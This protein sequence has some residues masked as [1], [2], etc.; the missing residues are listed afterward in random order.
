MSVILPRMTRFAFAL[1]ALS[2]VGCGGDDP[3]APAVRS[4][5]DRAADAR[6]PMSAACDPIDP[7]RCALPW[8]SNTFT[9][10]DPTSATRLRVAI[11][12]ALYPASDDPRE[13]NRADG[14]SRVSPV[15]TLVQGTVD[16]AMLGDG[17]GPFRVYAVR[18]G[19]LT[20]VPLRFRVIAGPSTTPE[21]LVIAYP[22]A[23]MAGAT[24][25]IAVVLDSLPTAEN[26]ALTASP[27]VRAALGLAAPSTD[28]QSRYRAY[29]APTRALLQRAGVDLARVARVWDF[30][31]RSREQPTRTLLAMRER[32]FRAVDAGEIRVA[33]DRVRVVTTGPGALDVAGRLT[34]V[35][36]FLDADG[37]IVRDA[38][39]APIPATGEE[40]VHEVPFRV[41]VP[42]GTGD[43]RVAMWGH[44]MGGDVTDT[45]FDAEIT[46]AGAAKVNLRFAGYYNDT[47][48]PSF[49]RFANMLKGAEQS[50]AGLLQSVADGA[51]I[52]R[53]LVGS[54]DDTARQAPLAQVLAAPMIMG[55]PNPV[56]GRYP[57]AAGAIWT[58]GSLGGTM[59]LVFMRSEPRMTAAV[60][61]VPGAGWSHYLTQSNLYAVARLVLNTN[62]R[63]DIDIHVVV[64]MAQ[65]NFDDADGAV[66]GGA[67]PDR[68]M[69][70]QES[71]GD[72]VLPNIGSELAAASVGASHVG[73]VLTAVRGVEP[74]AEVV[75]GSALTQFRVPMRVTQ[76]LDVHGFAARDT[77][78]GVAAREQIESFIRSVWDG[79]A[80]IS[81]PMTCARNTP[82]GSCD[83]SR[84]Q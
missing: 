74:V 84:G 40:G 68:P 57:R 72:P 3:G 25:H 77:Q 22:R 44:G 59:G 23:P 35:P 33:L 52:F 21:S 19:A 69:L 1:A 13:I 2:L 18:D 61:N 34:N 12:S 28:E 5:P 24:D 73:A 6:E 54:G 71:I 67:T 17:N 31:T 36:D 41:L 66:W 83:F 55:M 9:V 60:L 30:T 49:A 50:T 11:T 15:M 14:F 26:T 63:N 75:D 81:V 42:R 79:R 4:Y 20:P 32:L 27:L 82:A 64:G 43:Y 48:I 45:S 38:M 53:A 65:L 56:A 10:A 46:G 47:V 76:P 80:R 8:P 62:Y 37:R 29:H 16:P 70:L 7:S 58:G 51:V 78:A 39:G